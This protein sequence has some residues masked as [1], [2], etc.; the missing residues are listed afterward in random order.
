MIL[1][2]CIPSLFWAQSI[3]SNFVSVNYKGQSIKYLPG[4]YILKLRNG[5][6]IQ[7]AQRY[8]DTQGFILG[9]SLGLNYHVI[10]K[11]NSTINDLQWF[12]SSPTSH[13]FGELIPV[14][15]TRTDYIPND[16]LF[17]G[18]PSMYDTNYGAYNSPGQWYL[19]NSE[20]NP[21]ANSIVGADSKVWQAWDI[22]T[23]NENTVIVVFDT[24]ISTD[25]TGI[26]N[27]PELNDSNR[28]IKGRRYVYDLLTNVM[29]S[30]TL[31][32]SEGFSQSNQPHG[33]W[34][35]GIIGA[36]ANNDFGI[37]G[38]APSAMILVMKVMN[39]NGRGTNLSLPKAMQ[40]VVNYQLSNPDKRIIINMNPLH[41]L[42]A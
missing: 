5:T 3:D 23:G 9:Q 10:S 21:L 25:T 41:N 40:Y 2:L 26:L 42:R 15:A 29:D 39:D 35:T 28:I 33:T 27:H 20:S 7:E 24:G 32:V 34:M 36:E 31:N 22:N 17:L 30:D 6:N 13:V 1:I 37:S 16:D 4:H 38:V 12:N 8:L 18:D 19:K 11:M 14:T